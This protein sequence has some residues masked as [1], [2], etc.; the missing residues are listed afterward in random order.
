MMAKKQLINITH[1][2]WWP[3]RTCKY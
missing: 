3:R 1:V 2:T